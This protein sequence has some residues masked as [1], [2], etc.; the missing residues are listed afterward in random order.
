MALQAPMHGRWQQRFHLRSG[1]CP[2]PKAATEF[3]P[4]P[5]VSQN[6]VIPPVADNAAASAGVPVF[7][8]TAADGDGA[9]VANVSALL[10]TS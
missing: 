8:V 4:L 6:A 1:L 9:G 10:P 2:I 5:P 7:S 3:R